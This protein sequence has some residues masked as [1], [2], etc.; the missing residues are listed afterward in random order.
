MTMDDDVLAVRMSPDGSLLAVALLDCTVKVFKAADMKFFLSLFGHKL[1]VLSI[2]FSF[3]SR[4]L[5]SGSADKNIKIWGMDFGDCHKSLFAHSDSVTQ[6]AFVPRTHY[7]FSV[8]KDG[9]LKHWDT[10]KFELIQKLDGQ[11][12][13]SAAC[14]CVAV[15]GG[16]TLVVTSGHDRSIRVFERT[17][18]QLFLE[19]ERERELDAQFEAAIEEQ[20]DFAARN[21][22]TR[23]E[24]EAAS[25]KNLATVRSGEELMAAL[26]M[27][28]EDAA[29]QIVLAERASSA[30]AEAA[31]AAAEKNP[32]MMG[33]D[34]ADYV[35]RRLAEIPSGHLEQALMLLPFH[36]AASLLR[37][38]ATLIERGRRVELC[39]HCVFFLLRLHHAQIA[40]AAHGNE[41]LR[42]VDKLL[43]E[44]RKR[45]QQQKD[46]IGFNL[47]AMRFLQQQVEADGSGT[48]LFSDVEE[49]LAQ[50][51]LG[52]K[53]KKAKKKKKTKKSDDASIQVI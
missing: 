39:A 27:A 48:R 3:D 35:L 25:R 47:A 21:D 30:P 41:F 32:L 8:G 23:P 29:R 18:E 14:W 9:A 12:G 50:V 1:P 46:L 33:L 2:D 5:A 43:C 36:H 51:K 38:A 45:L 17:H 15:G 20:E 19:E 13:Q 11:R 6:I 40:A 37:F 52:A 28:E 26:D 22:P 42:V 49:K 7:L 16:G 31:A 10:D 44:T 53:Q 34:G 24:S 4:L